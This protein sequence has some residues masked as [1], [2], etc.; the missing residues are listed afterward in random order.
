MNIPN[1]NILTIHYIMRFSPG[2]K[3]IGIKLSN[4][5]GYYYF[6]P[7]ESIFSSPGRKKHTLTQPF[8]HGCSA[9]SG[10]G[11]KE[12]RKNQGGIQW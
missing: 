1:E 10:C 8:L 6:L 11:E 2:G 9:S 3:N 7:G 5:I 4:M 12:R